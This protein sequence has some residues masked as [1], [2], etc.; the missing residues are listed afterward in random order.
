MSTFPNSPLRSKRISWLS[1]AKGGGHCYPYLPFIQQSGG[2][3]CQTRE[4][5]PQ[6]IDLAVRAYI[7]HTETNNDR[8]LN[9]GMDRGKLASKWPPRC[10]QLNP[11]GVATDGR[12]CYLSRRKS[13]RRLCGQF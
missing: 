10:Q 9:R 6:A 3:L 7:R 12:L 5:D 1:P 4:F 13:G 2:A 11:D 8:L